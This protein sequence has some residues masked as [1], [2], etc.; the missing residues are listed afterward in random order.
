MHAKSPCIDY[1]NH[2]NEL[3][4]YCLYEFVKNT[5][6]D[7][8]HPSRLRPGSPAN[9]DRG[10]QERPWSQWSHYQTD[11]PFHL[12]RYHI[13]RGPGHN[14]VVDIVGPWLLQCSN[15]TPADMDCASLLLL[16]KPW[17]KLEELKCN[18]QSWME[19]YEEMLAVKPE[20][21]RPCQI[22]STAVGGI[23]ICHMNHL[24]NPIP[25][26]GW[27]IITILNLIFIPLHKTWK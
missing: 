16:L 21:L 15:E 10:E 22:S 3:E 12:T 8:I 27:A 9:E 2:G 13:V 7:T 25:G 17:H 4:S 24:W 26:P 1:I 14:T 11:H 20:L 23:I 5:Y 6:E 18:L 19:A